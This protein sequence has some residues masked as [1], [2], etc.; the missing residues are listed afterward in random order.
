MAETSS[1]QEL[2]AKDESQEDRGKISTWWFLG[3]TGVAVGIYLLVYWNWVSMPTALRRADESRHPERFIA[4]VAKQHLFEMS[5]VGP[6]VAGSYAN[7][8]LTVG[9]L[10]RVIEEVAANAHP[11]QHVD[12]EVQRATGDMFLDYTNYPQTSV[13]R[14][15]QNVIARI[16][17]ATG[18][19]PDNYLM[20]GSHFDS[21]P[22][23]PG[24]G[25]DGT[26]SVVML[27]VLRKVSQL[28]E[29][30]AHGL[31]FVFNGCEENTL[32]GSHAF[33]A[34]HR[35][36]HKVRAFINMDVAAN[37]GRDIMFQ[38]GP[39][40]SFLMKYY[41][42][43]VPHPYCTAVAEELFQA[44]LVP[45]ETDFYVYSKFGKVPGMDFAH[46]TWGY[47]Y[48]TAYD[49]YDTIPN[50]TLQ[51]TGDNVLAL[52]KA[53]ANA[54][55]LYA[56]GEHEGSK[57]VFF[58]FLNWFLV[59]YPLWASIL[60]NLGLSA[61]ALAAIGV[62]LWLTMR[63]TKVSL[64]SMSIQ[65]LV[66]VGVILLSILVGVGLSLVLGII[67]NAVGSSM[68]WFTQTWLIFGLYITP[69]LIATSTGPFLFTRF[70]R[71]DHLPLQARVQLLLHATCLIYII[72]LIVLTAMS[73]RSGYLFTLAILFYTA[74]TLVNLLLQHTT[75]HWIYVHLIGQIIPIAYYSSVSLTSF[76][77]FIPMQGRG[78]A[79]SNPEL[80][81]GLFGVLI[82]LLIAGFLTP[83][84]ALARKAYLFIG[85]QVV[86]FV[87]SIIVM[88]TAAGFPFRAHVTP[89]RYYVYHIER[90]F[91]HHNGTLR[92]SESKFYLHPQDRHTPDLIMDEVP[93]MVRATQLGD[94]CDRELY[95]GIPFYQ[96]SHHGQREN[97]WWLPAGKPNFPQ[98][99]DFRHTG[100][101]YDPGTNATTFRF[102]VTGTDH[103]SFYVSP[104]YGVS[105]VGWSFSDAIPRSGRSWNGQDVHY[106]NFVHGIDDSPYEFS[107]TTQG[108]ALKPWEAAWHFHLNVVAQ[109]MHHEEYRTEE[110]RTFI[111][112]FP[113]YAHVVA[114]PAYLESW[115]F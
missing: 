13:Y 21:V 83:L 40:Y 106:I 11:A 23:S 27:E 92:R 80:L 60:L 102:R 58:D 49:A 7:E 108:T 81:I 46:S 100:S 43:N 18:P 42:D 86:F 41:R 8:V 3:I 69:Y 104:V 72:I 103:M 26:M 90:N 1:E 62:S 17:P 94:E 114:Y 99:V 10:R 16:V 87:V 29:P 52:T 109:Y 35:W 68:S 33:V 111:G 53:L 31:V 5:N 77:T 64:R 93:E 79:G 63:R 4:E 71:N 34:H 61:V 98:P 38:A 37:G 105:L 78:N 96:N 20:L 24:A 28:P 91:Y 75:N 66:S 110:F 45:S 12:I 50:E 73:I 115:I 67:L 9:F 56:I 55:E 44:D 107:I 22:Q 95:C 14:G 51:H 89:Q 85:L 112:H 6:R 39:K 76:A 88:V 59:Y 101:Q 74:T 113:D 84:V 36:F 48:H 47:L 97:A 82:G 15:I 30:L 54:D 57:A 32:Q 65:C 25:D 2:I 70:V 19:D